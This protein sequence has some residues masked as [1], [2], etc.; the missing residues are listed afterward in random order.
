AMPEP[1]IPEGEGDADAYLARLC[2]DALGERCGRFPP[3]AARKRLASELKVIRESGYSGYFLIVREIVEFARGRGIPNLGRGSGANS[4]VSYLLRFTHVDPIAHDL[5]FERFLNPERATPP[6]VDLDFD[7]KRRGEILEFIVG[8]FGADRVARIGA[9][10]TFSLRSALRDLAKVKGIAPVDVDAVVSKLPHVAVHDLPEIAGKMP[11]GVIPS[12]DR[13]PWATL[14]PLAAAID[15]FPRHMTLHCGGIVISPAGELSRHA[16]LERGTSG[17]VMTQWD[18][19]DVEAAGLVKIDILGN[20]SLGVLADALADL[21]RKGERADVIPPERTYGDPETRRLL[22][23]GKTVGCFYIESPAMRSLNRR[24]KTETFEDL[25][26][27]SS[28]IRPGVAESGMM[29]QYIARHLGREKPVYLLPEMERLLAATHGVM[30]YQEDVLRVATEIAGLSHGE[31]DALR[32]AMS[33]KSRSAGEMARVEEVFFAS[34]ARRR[35]AGPV[36]REL[37]RQMRSFAGYSFCKAHSASYAQLSFQVCYLK[38]HHPA[39]FFAA[40]L[41]NG[42]G[43]YSAGAYVEEARRW[44]LAIRPPDVEDPCRIARGEGRR[45]R[46]GFDFLRGVSARL[47]GAVAESLNCDGPFGSLDRFWLR[48]RRFARAAEMERLAESGSLDV[49]GPRPEVFRKV[50]ER[51]SGDLADPDWSRNATI[52]RE[53]DAFGFAVSEHPLA[54][55]NERIRRHGIWLAADL[56]GAESGRAAACGFV[57]ARKRCATSKGELMEFATLEDATGLS[58]ITLFSRAYREFGG[59]LSCGRAVVAEGRLS[60]RDGS[61][62]LDAERLGLLADALAVRRPLRRLFT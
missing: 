2:R 61:V 24:L 7:T 23:E 16:P 55:Y 45:L 57:I 36:A 43:F 51:A 6:D 32:R 27:A 3:E 4:F 52:L 15:G 9:F 38:A 54:V 50:R 37:W 20:R 49:F 13:E 17:E 58:E 14:L 22:R 48:M 39:E 33:G 18:M 62:S 8:R 21:A 56:E 1:R 5:Y 35:I 44:G 28:V 12:L 25:V 19:H 34:C 30:I 47:A 10:S 46:L 26:A 42:G 60:S 40:V 11:K 31:A 41:N 53:R 59:L 29:E